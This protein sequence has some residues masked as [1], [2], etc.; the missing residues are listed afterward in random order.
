MGD[1]K[2]PCVNRVIRLRLPQKEHRIMYCITK[3]HVICVCKSLDPPHVIIVVPISWAS[4][5]IAVNE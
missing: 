4:K 2:N 3:F 1:G 5:F